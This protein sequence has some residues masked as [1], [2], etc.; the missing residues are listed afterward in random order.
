MFV[1]SV[2]RESFLKTI[3]NNQNMRARSY[4]LVYACA[5]SVVATVSLASIYST[6]CEIRDD[7]AVIPEIYA[8]ING[9]ED[10]VDEM[11]GIPNAV[12][13]IKA[14]VDEMAGRT[15]RIDGMLADIVDH[16][17]QRVGELGTIVDDAYK[18]PENQ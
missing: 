17:E 5:I 9:I 15:D 6:L 3:N 18:P 12:S 4:L 16:R 13:G 1:N 11:A 7:V 14:S 10:S 2:F 8:H